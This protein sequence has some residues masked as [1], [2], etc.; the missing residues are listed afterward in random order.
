MAPPFRAEQVGSLLRPKSLVEARKRSLLP[1]TN[2]RAGPKDGEGE[3]EGEGKNDSH[4]GQ[5]LEDGG[6]DPM[7]VLKTEQDRAIKDVVSDQLA[8][9]ILPVT[10]GEY[11]RSI[12][13]GNFFESLSGF[14][15]RYTPL[16]DFKTGFPTNRPLLEWG[17]PGRDAGFP[18]SGAVRLAKP[19]YLDDWLFLRSLLPEERWG[20]AKMTVPPPGWW[21]IQLKEPF[22]RALYATDEAL[23]SDLSAALRTEILTLYDAGLRVV[24]V[25]D[26]NL[27]FFC[28]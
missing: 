8:R 28:E 23:L 13:Y 16:S 11:E 3:G 7:E 25:D 26:P 27:S 18:T 20:D 19:A 24:Q 5:D 22:D 12:F 21:H 2:V 6:A 10:T 17:V 1:W 14:E 15:M 4:D 9:H